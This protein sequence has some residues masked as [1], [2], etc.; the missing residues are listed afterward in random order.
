VILTAT[1]TSPAEPLQWLGLEVPDD[2]GPDGLPGR[3]EQDVTLAR[4]S[5]QCE[6]VFSRDGGATWERVAMAA[7]RGAGETVQA[8]VN[9]VAG[10]V[11]LRYGFELYRNGEKVAALGSQASP[12]VLTLARSSGPA[13]AVRE[14]TGV[15]R[16][17]FGL[18]A[19]RSKRRIWRRH[20][21]R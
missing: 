8:T 10:Q 13:V 12:L 18:E 17:Y 11:D 19:W 7:V 2:D 4:A 15:V 14:A 1:Y 20:V 6:V 9:T 5:N 21:G 16:R 3:C